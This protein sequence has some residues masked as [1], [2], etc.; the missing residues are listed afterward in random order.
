MEDQVNKR[1]YF[2]RSVPTC[3]CVCVCVCVRARACVCTHAR[4]F[5]NK[6]W[7]IISIYIHTY[8]FVLLSFVLIQT[9]NM[10]TIPRKRKVTGVCICVHMCVFVCVLMCE[11]VYVRAHMGAYIPSHTVTS[12]DHIK[13]RKYHTSVTTAYVQAL[14]CYLY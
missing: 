7:T 14:P 4:V 5:S 12:H 11:C 3:E 2:V 6:H 8:I 10:L 1:G 13:K 9:K